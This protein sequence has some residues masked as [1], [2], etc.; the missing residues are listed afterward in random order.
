MNKKTMLLLC[1]AA[2]LVAAGI[3]FAPMISGS[4]PFKGLR[5]EDVRSIEVAARPPDVT[6]KITD[7]ARIAEIMD[8]IKSVVIYQKSDEWREYAGQ[9]MEYTLEMQSGGQVTLA[10]YYPFLMIDGQGY[11]TK[12]GPCEELNRLG[13]E[14]IAGI[15]KFPNMDGLTVLLG[16][17]Y[18]QIHERYGEPD[19]TLSGL[20]GDIYH[21]EDGT[22]F[23]IYYDED[24]SVH[25]IKV[26][27]MVFR[28]E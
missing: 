19:G 26:G 27:D 5:A 2:V 28:A 14:L 24:A 15:E 16:M 4:R 6:R 20:W 21:M 18:D 1:A 25:I 9:A 8:V 11:R 22:E 23:I 17:T 3:L 10:A 7:A 12:Y 13:N